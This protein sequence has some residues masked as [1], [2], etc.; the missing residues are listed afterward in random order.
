[1]LGTRF[2]F[3]D[4]CSKE[5]VTDLPRQLTARS[6]QQDD[7][8]S[9][10]R[11]STLP[12]QE[13]LHTDND[14]SQDSVGKSHCPGKQA[15]AH[16]K[17]KVERL[18][19]QAVTAL[20]AVPPE[21]QFDV[22]NHQIKALQ[23]LLHSTEQAASAEQQANFQK[24]HSV[25]CARKKDPIER[26][27][28]RASSRSKKQLCELGD[29]QPCKANFVNVSKNAVGHASK[30]LCGGRGFDAAVAH[31]QTAIDMG[32]T[33]EP[34]A[35]NR[36]KRRKEQDGAS[37]RAAN[38]PNELL[39]APSICGVLHAGLFNTQIQEHQFVS[40]GV[41]AASQ[42]QARAMPQM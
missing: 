22:M 5:E 25:S 12:Q 27:N 42:V 19:S 33:G 37:D 36:K 7:Q 8:P 31:V 29:Q 11:Q 17:E 40:S 41:P 15:H 18:V 2:G 14:R 35:Q 39:R 28:D 30:A 10:Q 4:D 38:V 23:A 34:A 32:H 1:L 6:L 13:V 3:Y 26:H 20:H 21:V 24:G 16:H 9:N